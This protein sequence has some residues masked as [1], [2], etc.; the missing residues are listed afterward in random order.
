VIAV[1]NRNDGCILPI[2]LL[3][4]HAAK[5]SE[6]SRPRAAANLTA[7]VERAVTL[8]DQSGGRRWTWTA[9]STGTCAARVGST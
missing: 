5:G 8:R 7:A 9:T 2:P 4:A 1:H 3:P 6:R